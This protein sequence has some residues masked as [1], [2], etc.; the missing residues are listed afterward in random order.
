M[1]QTNQMISNLNTKAMLQMGNQAVKTDDSKSVFSEA[2]DQEIS[3]QEQTVVDEKT[4]QAGEKEPAADKTQQTGDDEAQNVQ[5]D[6][7][8]T[9]QTEA[10]AAA[11]SAWFMQALVVQQP[12]EE[13]QEV[14]VVVSTEDAASQL[15]EEAAVAEENVAATAVTEGAEAVFQINVNQTADAKGATDTGIQ[16]DGLKMAAQEGQAVQ[17][18]VVAEDG[19]SQQMQNNEPQQKQQAVQTAEVAA[20]DGS[21][22]AAVQ[23]KQAVSANQ[24][25]TQQTTQ[26]SQS[27]TVDVRNPQEGMQNLGKSVADQINQ[28]KNAFEL[29]LEPVNLGK[30]GIKV[31]Y[32]GGRAM[33]QIL[34][35]SDKAMELIAQNAKTLGSIIQQ[36]TGT[37]TLVVVE[38]PEQQD[39]LQKEGEQQNR[40]GE[41]P[42]EQKKD[43]G[44]NEEE[45]ETQSFL[46]QLRLGLK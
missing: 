11:D 2:L 1:V 12:A 20:V 15:M 42:E 17:A 46:Q 44:S 45:A 9:Q 21:E 13:M 26:T 34:C 4:S 31:A 35:M 14:E 10:P 39:Y 27:Q 29:W 22:E 40:D 19:E 18:A 37:N 36:N 16:T 3:N 32:E 43:K 24:T 6:Q 41:Q 7:Q 25:G 28:G 38:Q 23:S 8:E 33:I 30:I 5:G